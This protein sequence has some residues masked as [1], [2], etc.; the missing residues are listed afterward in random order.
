MFCQSVCSTYKA[1][2]LL[3]IQRVFV[4]SKMP[5]QSV[6]SNHDV[7]PGDTYMAVLPKKRKTSPSARKSKSSIGTFHYFQKLPV[8]LRMAIWELA[9]TGRVVTIY[10]C[11]TDFVLPVYVQLARR[12]MKANDQ[13]R[14]GLFAQFRLVPLLC[15]NKE[16]RLTILLKYTPLFEGLVPGKLLLNF[17]HDTLRMLDPRSLDAFCCLSMEATIES[18]FSPNFGEEY[19]LSDYCV[20]GFGRTPTLS[21]YRNPGINDTIGKIVY[22]VKS[23]LLERG[24]PPQLPAME[25]LR[26][27]F[28]YAQHK[29]ASGDNFQKCNGDPR[30]GIKVGK[31]RYHF[32]DTEPE[33]WV[34][35]KSLSTSQLRKLDQCILPKTSNLS[36]QSG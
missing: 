23:I 5:P 4:S 16:S 2:Y 25:A 28:V 7:R 31:M 8:E 3:I 35:V 9:Q 1:D 18:R 15:V 33:W 13:P 14:K 26:T 10:E 17:E 22:G 29:R 34:D 12:R 32:P 24:W 20:H 36:N 27:V 11:Q 6:S 30:R 19:A 21:T